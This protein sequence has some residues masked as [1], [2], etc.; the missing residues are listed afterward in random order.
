MSKVKRK[1][2][3]VQITFPVTMTKVQAQ[4]HLSAALNWWTVKV[5]PEEKLAIKVLRK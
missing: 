3:T 1:V 2:A 4:R 5:V